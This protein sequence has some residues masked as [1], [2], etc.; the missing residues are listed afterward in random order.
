MKLKTLFF[1]LPLGAVVGCCLVAWQQHPSLQSNTPP[2]VTFTKPPTNEKFAWG[3]T[4]SYNVSVEDKE[5][6]LSK[7]DEIA[8][9]EVFLKIKFL[10]DSGRA[11]TYMAREIKF[12]ELAALTAIK[13]SDCFNCHA[14]KSKVM[15]PSFETM[16]KQYANNAGAVTKLS[17]IIIRGS[18]KT[19]GTVKMPAHPQI[20]MAKANEIVRWILNN[21]ADSTVDYVRGLQ[22]TF[23]TKQKPLKNAG[24]AVYVLTASYRDHGLKG[25]PQQLKEGK[26]VVMLKSN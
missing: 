10:P 19:T 2:K 6:G 23:R 7:Y 18:E 11:K 12:S 4:I 16:A 13:T 17:N 24:K 15:G 22:G 9:N 21:A 5:D 14:V 1:L 8:T 26:H 25:A 3:S 20:S